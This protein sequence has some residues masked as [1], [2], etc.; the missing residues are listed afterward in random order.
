MDRVPFVRLYMD[1]DPFGPFLKEAK[2][3][4]AG[5]YDL[6]LCLTDLISRTKLMPE[7]LQ[8]HQP[9]WGELFSERDRSLSSGRLA[10]SE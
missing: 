2:G 8:S 4:H 3:P 5:R 7:S 10:E 6:I 1:Y 9:N